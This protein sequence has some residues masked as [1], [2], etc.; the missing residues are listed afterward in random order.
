MRKR[1]IWF[2]SWC[3]W[4]VVVVLPYQFTGTKLGHAL[5]PWAGLYGYTDGGWPEF[6]QRDF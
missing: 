5:L 3:C 1:A 2:W 6:K 4:W